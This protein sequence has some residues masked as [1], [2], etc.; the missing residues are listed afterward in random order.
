ME[1]SALMST[2][3]KSQI[4]TDDY[5]HL[6][7]RFPLVPIRN[8]RH[9]KE[10]HK[11]IDELSIIDPDDLTEGQIAYLEVISDLTSKFE[12]PAFD[13]LTKDVT[14]LDVLKHLMEENNLNGSDVG[15]IIG[16]REMGAK[17]LKGDRLISREHARLLGKH[18]G[19]PGELFLRG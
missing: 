12:T 2:R 1:G 17:V 19:L 16:Q 10:A 4:V 5:F 14:G 11:I 6:I 15:R 8:D 3:L 7:Q 18:F 9:L 13:E